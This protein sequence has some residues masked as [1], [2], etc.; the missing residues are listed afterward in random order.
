MKVMLQHVAHAR[1]GDKGDTSNIAVFAYTP[2]LYPLLKE[3]LTAE[4]F[5]AFYRGAIKG[6]VTRYEADNLQALNFVCQG[7]LGG[8][9]SRSLCLDNY[10]KALSAA[11]LGFEIEVPDALRGQLRGQ[12]LLQDA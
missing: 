6:A 5:K 1:S 9:V 11:V 7:A 10:G 2:E 12:H 8:G 4:R 3:Q